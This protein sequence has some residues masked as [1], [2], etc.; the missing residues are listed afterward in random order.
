MP[1]DRFI[2]IILAVLAAA[3]LTIFIGTALVAS[4]QIGNG[5]GWLI[6]MPIALVI[7]IFARVILDRIGNREDD[8][9]DRI[10]K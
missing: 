1:L 6:F 9:Y 2:L 4:L 7:Y 5:F 3:G 10:E 8:T